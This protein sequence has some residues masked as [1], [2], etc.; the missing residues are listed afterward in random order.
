MATELRERQQTQERIG[1]TDV[2]PS[3]DRRIGWHVAVTVV[4]LLAV[5]GAAVLVATQEDVSSP[6][7]TLTY[8]EGASTEEREG[9]SYLVVPEPVAG[10]TDTSVQIREGG[11]YAPTAGYG[12]T[13]VEAREGGTY[14]PTTGY[15]D[16]SVQIRE[17]GAY[18]PTAGYT[19]TSVEAREG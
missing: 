10:F 1:G 8:P 9:G 12:D 17:G 6:G 19:E 15:G 13:S 4:A 14:A 16:T 5:A 3:R 18:A 7:I 11:A 2:G